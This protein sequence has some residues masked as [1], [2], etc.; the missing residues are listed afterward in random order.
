LQQIRNFLSRRQLPQSQDC[1]R[2]GTLANL[3][4]EHNLNA[5]GRF[6]KQ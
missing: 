3:Q 1:C 6:K 2:P 5:G 4:S